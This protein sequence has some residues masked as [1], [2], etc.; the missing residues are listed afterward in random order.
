MLLQWPSHAPCL[1]VHLSNTYFHLRCA[2]AAPTVVVM[3]AAVTDA[4]LTALTAPSAMAT[5]TPRFE[6]SAMCLL[7][8]PDDLLMIVL[9]KTLPV[10]IEPPA[11]LPEGS[12]AMQVSWAPA[13]VSSRFRRCFLRCIIETNVGSYRPVS[14]FFV[15]A[16]YK[17]GKQAFIF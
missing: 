3:E 9:A 7:D 8:L 14:P 15:V 17:Q 11:S 4:G 13:R 12:A 10:P 2:P 16:I 6:A 5:S 1:S